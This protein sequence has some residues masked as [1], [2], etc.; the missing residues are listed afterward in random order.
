LFGGEVKLNADQKTQV[1]VT[2]TLKGMFEAYKKKDL[3]GI[4]SYWAPDPDIVVIGSG[5]DEKVVGIGKYVESLMR[6]WAQAEVI[7]IGVKNFAISAAGIVAWFSA[8]V[9]FTYRIQGKEDTLPGRMT[10][11]ME[12]RNG[13]WLWVQMHYSSPSINQDKGQS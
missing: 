10:G 4:L 12:K 7:S 2:Q 6:D 13:K 8:E 3:S 1:E 5:E 9:T 11:V